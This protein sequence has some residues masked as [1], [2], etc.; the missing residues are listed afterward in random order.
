MTIERR[1]MANGIEPLLYL[2]SGPAN[3]VG[4]RIVLMNQWW[5]IVIFSRSLRRLGF[6]PNAGKRLV[7][8][9]HSP[10]TVD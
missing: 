7:R 1:F 5:V 4:G 2:S 6:C 9:C 10:R 3:A 8:W